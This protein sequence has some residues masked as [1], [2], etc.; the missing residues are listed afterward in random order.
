MSESTGTE[1]LTLL[2]F[3]LDAWEY[4][5]PVEDIREV[6]RMVEITPVPE[7]PE[8]L[9]GF[10]DMRGDITSVIDLR[11]RL[12]FS[13]AEYGL[14]TPIIVVNVNEHNVGFVVD[15]VSEVVSVEPRAVDAPAADVPLP[16]EMLKGVVHLENRMMLVLD[17]DTLV[18][19]E[20]KAI[21]KRIAKR[22]RAKK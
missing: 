18:T 8:F 15:R 9:K 10:I 14:S 19:F 6:L 2:G 7:A 13:A 4:G 11:L 20:D 12:G 21:L 17:V 3:F 5:L 16:E 1:R 22:K